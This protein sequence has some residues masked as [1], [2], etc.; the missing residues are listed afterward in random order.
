MRAALAS[1]AYHRW[2]T[3][4]PVFGHGIVERGPHLVQYM[5]I[6]SHHTWHGLLFVKGAVGFLGLAI[7]LAWSI[8]E[9]ALKAQ[10]DRVARAGLGVMLAFAAVLVRRQPG[11]RRLSDLAGHDGRRH[12]A[13]RGR[14]RNPFT[15]YLG[16]RARPTR[17]RGR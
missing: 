11:D 17:A 1:I 10:A 5:P 15:A 14:L 4:A 2:V 8:V 16:Q 9:L 13:W 3:E 6:G 12:R 7:P